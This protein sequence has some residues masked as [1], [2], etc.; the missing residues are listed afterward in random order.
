MAAAACSSGTT[1]ETPGGA[2]SGAGGATTIDAG[3]VDAADAAQAVDAAIPCAANTDCGPSLACSTW[4]CEAAACV[5]LMRPAGLA[6]VT[7]DGEQ[8]ECSGADNVCH[9]PSG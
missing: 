4:G 3:V 6:C 2:A 5:E 7:D 8:G 1:T 9:P